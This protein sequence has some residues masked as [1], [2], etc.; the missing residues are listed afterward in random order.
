[1]ADTPKNERTKASA[2]ELSETELGSVN[3]GGQGTSS[4]DDFKAV[5]KGTGLGGSMIQTDE[6]GHM[7]KKAPSSLHGADKQRDL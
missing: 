3:G 4:Q 5:R 7:I 1:M 2:V 6:K